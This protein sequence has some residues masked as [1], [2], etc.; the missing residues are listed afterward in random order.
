MEMGVSI[1]VTCKVPSTF[2]SDCA[3]PNVWL[4]EV[5]DLQQDAATLVT[6]VAEPDQYLQIVPGCFRAGTLVHLA[7]G[8]CRGLDAG[9]D[10]ATNPTDNKIMYILLRKHC[11]Q[12]I[13]SHLSS[14]IS[15]NVYRPPD[16]VYLPEQQTL[17]KP[18]SPLFTKVPLPNT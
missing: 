17:L 18:P 6:V 12:F 5:Q 15:W 7:T 10:D 8:Q 2:E 1:S 13:S 16:W 11:L 14:Q 3:I 4:W 9:T